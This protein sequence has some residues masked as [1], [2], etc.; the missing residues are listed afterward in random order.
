MA[1]VVASHHRNGF[2]LDVRRKWDEYYQLFI[3]IALKIDTAIM[4]L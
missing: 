3:S 2:K 1:V 4:A